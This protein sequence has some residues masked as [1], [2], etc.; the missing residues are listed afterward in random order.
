MLNVALFIATHFP[1]GAPCVRSTGP[2]RKECPQ[3][4]SAAE[5]RAQQQHLHGRNPSTRHG[6]TTLSFERGASPPLAQAQPSTTE[7]P[8]IR[9]QAPLSTP[10]TW[11]AR[12]G[13]SEASSHPVRRS[14]V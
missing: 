5:L 8:R 1:R 7:E 2:S 14:G 3:R 4:L 13:S 6:S 11:N 10:C 9:N 12:E